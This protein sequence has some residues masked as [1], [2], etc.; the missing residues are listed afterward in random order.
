M[1][2]KVEVTCFTDLKGSVEVNERLGNEQYVR[3]ITEHIRIAQDLARRLGGTYHKNVGDAHMLTFE[4][5]EPGIMFALQLQE[6][7]KTQPALVRQDLSLRVA[8]FL[9]VVEPTSNDVFG[10]GVNQASRLESKTQPSQVVV[11]LDLVEALKRAWGPGKKVECF[12]SIGEHTLDGIRSPAKQELFTF[13]WETYSRS[14]PDEG[15]SRIVYEHLKQARVEPSLLGPA[16]LSKPGLVI[17]PVV[18]REVATAIHRGQTETVRL[19]A[20]LGWKVKLLIADCGARNNYEKPYSQQFCRRLESYLTARGIRT[21]ETLFLSDFFEVSYPD[22]KN[23]QQ[24]FR[25][26]ASD[27]TLQDLLNINNKDYAD[28]VKAEIR[29]SAT[30]DCLRPALSLAA[31]LYLAQKEDQKSVIISG[32]D[33]KIQ[34]ERAYDIPPDTRNII[35]VLMNPVLKADAT[36]QSRQRRAWPSWSSQES[37]IQEMEP[38]NLAWW[39][40]NLHA[41]I[42]AFP[43]RSVTIGGAEFTADSWTDEL[44]IPT[45]LRKEA[46]A[47]HVWQLLNPAT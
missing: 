16:D 27:L 7:C 23:I 22:Y 18:P 39:V 17:W 1:P 12:T 46:L 47:E 41:L 40:F 38:G 2:N 33:E 44:T 32:A 15:L 14:F 20:L 35:G 34:W 8:L 5:L 28:D 6:Y 11:N 9:G 29:A 26:I 3:E 37:L 36:H 45:N 24:I 19:L 42:P 13:D 10:S 21:D 4:Y 30:L 43:N 25:T 31:V